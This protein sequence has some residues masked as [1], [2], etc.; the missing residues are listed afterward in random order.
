MPEVDYEKY[1]VRKPLY[2]SCRGV[3]NRQSPVMTYM[4]SALVPE[5]NYYIKLGWIYDIPEPNP[6]IHE[7]VH[8]YDQI[9]LYWS[10][11]P[12]EPQVLGGEIEFYIGGQPVTFNTT[13]GIFIPRG[14]K[15]GPATW[16]KFKKPHIEMAMM[17]GTGSYEQG[18]ADSGIDEPEKELPQKAANIDYERYVIRSPLGELGDPTTK[19]RQYPSMTY[20]SRLQIPEVNYY[21]EFSWLYAMP[22]P[23]PHIME[24]VHENYDE[25]VLHIGG[26]PQNPED[27]GAE[28]EFCVGGQPLTFNTN[29][30]LF[31]PRGVK[32]GPLTWK[33]FRKPH[34]EMAIMLGAGTFAEGWGGKLPQ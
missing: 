21:I 28:I 3:K 4:S 29:T 23:N 5:V 15:H 24:H 17:L 26:D 25:I 31:L 18:W 34:L 22:E 14:V 11:D 12:D 7:H 32:H 33:E 20:M 13:T 16:K 27:L 1:L 8:A 6:H 9:L 30:A 10:G 19:G 2:E